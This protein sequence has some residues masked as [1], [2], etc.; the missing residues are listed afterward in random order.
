MNAPAAGSIAP[1][2][3]RR[4]R[5]RY[6]NYRVHRTPAEGATNR[7]Q[8]GWEHVISSWQRTR[9]TDANSGVATAP[10]PAPAWSPTSTPAL[11]T[12]HPAELTAAGNLLFFTA[13]E[14][15]L[16][17]GEPT[18][19]LRRELWQTDGTAAGTQRVDDLALGQS[20][21][22]PAGLVADGPVLYFTAIAGEQRGYWKKDTREFGTQRAAVL[23][24]RSYPTPPITLAGS[25]AYVTH[26]GQ[27]W[28]SDGTA[29]GTRSSGELT[30]GEP[31]SVHLQASRRAVVGNR[32]FLTVTQ[33]GS[34]AALWSTD[35]TPQGTARL[36]VGLPNQW[37]SRPGWPDTGEPFPHAILG[38]RLVFAG[39]VPGRG[40]EPCI[41]DG[42][43]AGT[44]PL[45]DINRAADTTFNGGQ[46]GYGGELIAAGGIG[47]FQACTTNGLAEGKMC[48]W[49]RTDGTAAGTGTIDLQ[50]RFQTLLGPL[51]GEMYAVAAN[52][53]PASLLRL[54]ADGVTVA[55]DIGNLRSL[56]PGRAAECDGRLYFAAGDEATGAELCVTDGTTEGTRLIRDIQP[57]S[58]TSNPDHLTALGT[59]LYFTAAETE[60]DS[61][62]WSSDGTAEGTVRVADIWPGPT[63]SNPQSLTPCGDRL[64]FIADDGRGLGLWQ[65]DGTA[66]GTVPVGHLPAAERPH[67]AGTLT[68]LGDVLYFTRRNA[69]RWSL[70]R[71]DGT[72]A[73]TAAVPL[74]PGLTIAP[75]LLAVCGGQL[76][77][78]GTG[79][80]KS[81][82]TDTG[83]QTAAL[84]NTDGTPQGT[85]RLREL[86]AGADR[87]PPAVF[88]VAD[89]LFLSLNEDPPQTDG[90]RIPL[91][92]FRTLWMS[93][94]SPAGTRRVADL[95]PNAATAS[96]Q[97]LGAAGD[98]FYFSA[99]DG[100]HGRELWAF[101]LTPRPRSGS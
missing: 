55:A 61:E 43:V 10:Q 73:G 25:L 60:Y 51:A 7:P 71:S 59:R 32:L 88:R 42:T 52:Q 83:S 87:V 100:T 90:S 14:P 77:F 49:W 11:P 82:S 54:N 8:R 24:E 12:P 85:V 66:V 29:A 101:D 86:P 27:L 16:K 20:S 6:S 76:C 74:A 69:G 65:T 17:D 57:G 67:Y 98:R 48:G 41:S 19:G 45:A 80:S 94:G 70:W 68:A 56:Q 31:L 4:G 38:D 81:D 84:W 26:N 28:V 53:Q 39:I 13:Y 37:M 50:H 93:D 5:F 3:H 97:P 23:P 64:Y 33:N 62:L 63:G 89:T 1:T 46:P 35:G 99:D 30:A 75:G 21:T 78:I 72:A 96:P 22:E 18:R 95:I 36:P 47:Y 91:R 58:H 15:I 79:G 40:L 34:D 9:R 2:A 92:P 44:Q